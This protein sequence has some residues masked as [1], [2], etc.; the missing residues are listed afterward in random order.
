MVCVPRRCRGERKASG[1]ILSRR[2]NKSPLSR[3]AFCVQSANRQPEI[4]SHNSPLR[5]QE[6]LESPD[7]CEGAYERERERDREG[8]REGGPC[9]LLCLSALLSG[10]S[11]C[12]LAFWG[13]LCAFCSIVDHCV[14]QSIGQRHTLAFHANASGLNIFFYPKHPEIQNCKNSL[15][16]VCVCVCKI[17]H[18]MASGRRL[19]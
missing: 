12:S 13:H 8:E 2:S 16:L 15:T 10:C 4:I 17:W 6:T 1:W 14:T 18:G 7:D 5:K 19:I 9:R 3:A 11:G